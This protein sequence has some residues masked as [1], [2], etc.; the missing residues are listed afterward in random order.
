MSAYRG[1][2]QKMRTTK[3]ILSKTQMER[4]ETQLAA[5]WEEFGLRVKNLLQTEQFE[6]VENA[7]YELQ[8]VDVPDMEILMQML[9]T[10]AKWF[11]VKQI[12]RGK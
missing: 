12:E 11:T 9:E 2:P 4:R 8:R 10:G 5:A 6:L 3:K 1:K 7:M